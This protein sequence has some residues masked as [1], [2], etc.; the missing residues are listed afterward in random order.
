MLA[1]PP[2][3]ISR[4]RSSR[5]SPDPLP[6]VL[7]TQASHGLGT[8]YPPLKRVLLRN[9]DLQ[10]R[11][12]HRQGHRLDS[13]DTPHVPRSSPVRAS[14]SLRG[15]DS[16]LIFPI[17]LLHALATVVAQANRA[18]A[19]APCSQAAGT[20]RECGVCGAALTL[21]IR[22]DHGKTLCVK[23]A[24]ATLDYVSSSAWVFSS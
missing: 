13:V 23:S 12:S 9:A 8:A 14:A 5:R 20:P 1:P 6:A 16:S 2:Q 4:C 21:T 24:G 22:R 11:F 10:P 18:Q 19:C 7:P 15:L 17:F 3:R